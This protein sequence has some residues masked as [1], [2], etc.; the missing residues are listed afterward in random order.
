VAILARAQKDYSTEIEYCQK[1]LHM[2]DEY[3]SSKPEWGAN[4]AESPI[5]KNIKQRM[6]KAEELLNKIS[7]IR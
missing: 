3:I 4:I 1:Y 2:A 7:H 6:L 5:Y